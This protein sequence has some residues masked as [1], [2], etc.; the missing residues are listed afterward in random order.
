MNNIKTSISKSPGEPRFNAP[1]QGFNKTLPVTKKF[2]GLDPSSD[3]I[4]SVIVHDLHWWTTDQDLVDLCKELGINVDLKNVQFLEHKVNGKSKGQAS[5]KC[6]DK[7]QALKLNDYLR[8]NPFQGKRIPSALASSVGGNPLH[9]ANQDFPVVRPLSTAIHSTVRHPTN[10][11]GGVNFNR[12]RPNSRSAIHANLG[13][14]HPGPAATTQRTFT[15][16]D[17]NPQANMIPAM[18]PIDPAIAWSSQQGDSAAH[19]GYGR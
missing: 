17:F 16:G 3:E 5:I 9:P 19:F 10:A 12:V 2:L 6:Q 7:A 8:A 4:D 13:M 15:M 14:G 11:H 1:S 18:I